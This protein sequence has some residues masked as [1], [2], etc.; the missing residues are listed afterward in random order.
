MDRDAVCNVAGSSRELRTVLGAQQHTRHAAAQATGVELRP[1]LPGPR[2]A[3]LPATSP[4]LNRVPGPGP[5]GQRSPP[6]K[7]CP[8]TCLSSS[9]LPSAR[10]VSWPW[11]SK[12]TPSYVL[13]KCTGS[14]DRL[15]VL[16]PGFKS[17]LYHSLAE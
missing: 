7:A 8:M 15:P 3:P 1:G 13:G 5:L 12:G 17:Y 10:M 14:E 2:P 9:A 11:P 4:T 6:P 16:L